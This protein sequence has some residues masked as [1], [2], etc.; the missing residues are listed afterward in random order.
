VEFVVD[1]TSSTAGAAGLLGLFYNTSGLTAYY[2]RDGD[3]SSHAITLVTMTLGT[4]V[5]GGF[6]V[7][8]ATG[9]PGAYSLGVPNAAFATGAG[10]V[11]IVLKG[12]TNM[13]QVNLEIELTGPDNQDAVRGGLSALPNGPT[14]I[15]KN[16]AL[17]NFTMEFLSDL[18]GKTPV[19]G[20]AVTLQRSLDG[21]AFFTSANSPTEIALGWYTVNLAAGDTNGDSIIYRG[22]SAGGSG[23]SRPF[24]L[25]VYT[26]P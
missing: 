15:K 8:D 19:T 25:Q 10:S 7:V 18:D 9:Q 17:N 11:F 22:T 3:T 20:A 6:V 12:V 14:R 21:A 4:W 26:Q 16:T 1:D 24:R 23:V 13:G 5:S 2:Y